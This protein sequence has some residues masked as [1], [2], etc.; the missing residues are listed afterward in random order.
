M[1]IPHVIAPALLLT[2]LGV[3]ALAAEPAPEDRA[4]IEA[5]ARD[6]IDG[7]YEGDAVRMERALHPDLAKRTLR[8]L[9]DGGGQVLSA[10]SASAMVTY[11]RAGIGAKQKRPDQRNEVIILDVGRDIASVKTVTPD[12]VDYIHMARVDGRW[13]IVNV[14][15]EPP[16]GES[17]K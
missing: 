14:L 11:T 8:S 3:A 15:W 4:A 2:A 6:Y 5:C 10:L 16:A 13:R 17:P 9:P 7:W 12:F 1:K